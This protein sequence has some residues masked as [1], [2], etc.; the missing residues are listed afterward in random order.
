MYKSTSIILMVTLALMAILITT[1]KKEA[2]AA[3]EKNLDK[4]MSASK[5]LNSIVLGAGCFW[6]AEKSYEAIPGV[7]DAVSG[8]A[9]GVDIE[10]TYKEITKWKYRNNLDNYAEVVKVT[11]NSSQIEL[12][13]ILRNYFETHDP[14]QLNSQGNDIG[15]QYRSTI[16][17]SDNAQINKA[18]AV[19]G[20]Y[21]VRLNAKGF[22]E[23]VTKIK[24]LTT[25]FPAED[26]HQDYLAKKPKRL[27]PRSLNGCDIC[28]QIQTARS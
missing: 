17:T 7:V 15:T 3:T 11:Y 28:R 23:I 12:E 8:Y 18:K 13:T 27:L 6:G 19:L 21:Q 2:F 24:P 10:P 20:Q 14:T 22:G 1:N 5:H 26:Y 25:F 4:S 16:L 9:D